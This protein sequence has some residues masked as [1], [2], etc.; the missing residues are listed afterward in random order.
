M[1]TR[2]RLR[3]LEAVIGSVSD[4]TDTVV[5]ENDGK[6]A[7]DAFLHFGSGSGG[8]ADLINY[9]S[10]MGWS[11]SDNRLQIIPFRPTVAEQSRAHGL[12]IDLDSFFTGEVSG[13]NRGVTIN[14]ERANSGAD[15]TGDSHDWGLSVEYTNRAQ[16]AA[17]A[18]ARAFNVS[19]QNRQSG[20]AAELRGA[21]IAV[22]QRGD[23]G[24]VGIIRGQQT[25]VQ[26]NVG[27]AVATSYVEGH[28]VE[29]QLEAHGP[30]HSDTAGSAAFIADQRTDGQY[31]NLP[32]AFAVRNRGTSNCDG[33]LYGMD[34]YDSRRPT[35]KNAEIRMMTADSGGLP[36][37]IATT[38]G[39]DDNSI[40][41]DLGAD[42]SIA[43]GSIAIS[44]VDGS[45]KLFQKQN[46]VWIDMQ[47]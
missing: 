46:D 16:L 14:G 9:D 4:T 36:C 29:M 18:Y 17:G 7:D 35:C 21:M 6:F 11:A 25:D 3:R 45:G 13:Q 39:T 24:T 26:V 2:K 5:Q 20:I 30:A 23:G 32:M 41:A 15:I 42:N 31:N 34:F 28:R 1:L 27:A 37:I 40:R 43:D 10:K 44:V 12:H 47:A 38:T 8:L 22:R 33:F 19:A